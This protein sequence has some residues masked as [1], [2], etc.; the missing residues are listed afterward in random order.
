[1]IGLEH[2]RVDRFLQVHPVMQMA[3][4]ESQ[5]PLVLIVAAGRTEH[6]VGRAVAQYQIDRQRRA[7]PSAG[8]ERRRKALFEPEHLG[9]AGQA[10]TELRDGGGGVQ[11]TA[12]GRRRDHV[13]V[14]VDDIEMTGV[15]GRGIGFHGR[16]A[17][18]EG[19]VP[20]GLAAH[21]GR[22]IDSAAVAG[23][24][25][26]SQLERGLFRD[27]APAPVVVVGGKQGLD[28][29]LDEIG[30][31]IEGLAVRESELRGLGDRVDEFGTHR[32]HGSQVGL[33]QQRQLLQEHRSLAP[34]S[35]LAEGMAV[36]IE[37][38]RRLLG[39]L[40]NGHVVGRQ[41]A[42]VT[43]ARAIYQLLI[44]AKGADRFRHEAAVPGVAQA[45]DLV[46]TIRAFGL[47]LVEQTLVGL[48]QGGVAE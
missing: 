8:R 43:P 37:G 7:R 12:R 31:A 33:C 34:N 38:C 4:G 45:L 11:P 29:H 21:R 28:R 47:G 46:F 18:A 35:V 15:A 3:Q 40:P 41:D 20:D 44:R 42:P 10:E 30:I 27:K 2:G 17:A 5:G 1:V 23:N 48:R 22:Q 25:S 9:A 19:R 24:R 13:A 6:H 16:F 26:R 36:I 14:T 39:C 32:V